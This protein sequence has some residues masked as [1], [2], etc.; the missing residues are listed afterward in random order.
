MIGAARSASVSTVYNNSRISDSCLQ[1]RGWACIDFAPGITGTMCVLCARVIQSSAPKTN[2]YIT[3]LQSCSR[4][5]IAPTH[6]R[7][8]DYSIKTA[9][10]TCPPQELNGLKS[11]TAKS[12]PAWLQV[13]P[14]SKRSCL[15][16]STSTAS[17]HIPPAILPNSRLQ[18]AVKYHDFLQR[19]E[20]VERR[21]QFLAFLIEFEMPTARHNDSCWR[22]R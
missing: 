20:Q 7:S 1:S 5:S 12:L 21:P 13:S 8:S 11:S 4:P 14:K 19:K 18:S 6:A 3:F 15:A 10:C 22:M 9:Q 17:V 16:G 2:I